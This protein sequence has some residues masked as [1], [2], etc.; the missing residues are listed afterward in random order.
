MKS[1]RH[2][3][4]LRR[5]G[6]ALHG[7]PKQPRLRPLAQ[8]VKLACLPTGIVLGLS[9]AGAVAGPQGGQIVG[10]QGAIVSPNGATTVINQASHNIAI[11]WDT[12]NV[13]VN[14]LVRFNQPGATSAA[15]NNIFDQSAS[16]IF[17]QIDANGRVFLM[18]PNGILFGPNA[19]IN[20]N[21]LVAAGARIDVDDFMA[22]NYT[23]QSLQDADGFVINRGVIEAATGGSVTLAGKTVR[24]EGLILA[25]AGRVNLVTGSRIALDFDG[26]GLMQFAVE[27]AVLDNA[28]SIDDGIS[29]T[30]DIIAD[31]GEVLITA[32]AAQGV[33]DNAINNE[34]LIK[35]GRI[36]NQG[37]TIRLVGMGPQS[38]IINTGVLTADASSGDGGS[39]EVVSSATTIIG[40][41]A[42]VSA[43]ADVGQG[44]S[45][46]IL[47]DRV[48]LTDAASIDVSGASGGEIL[49]GGDYQGNNPDV[50]NA[51][52]TYVGTDATLS[53]DAGTDG[54]GGRIIVWADGQTAF[55]GHLSAR[56]GSV[57][58]DGGF[59]EV[60]GKE[61]LQFAGT[62]DMQAPQGET[63][64]LLLD[65]ADIIIEGGVASAD[66][67]G[68]PGNAN[69]FGAGTVTISEAVIEGL[70]ADVSLL[71]EDTITVTGTF[72]QNTNGEGT[73]AILA[74]AS[75]K[76]LVM[77]TN[78]STATGGIDLTGT[79]VEIRTQGDGTITLTT[80]VAAAGKASP[81]TV[82]AITTGP[83]ASSGTDADSGSITLTAEGAITAGALTTGSATVTSAGGNDDATS[84]SITLTAGAGLITLNGALTTG[85]ASI[86]NGDSDA[87]SG[88]I[89]I[90][91]TNGGL[92]GTAN[93][94][95]TTGNATATEVGGNDNQIIISGSIVLNVDGAIVL[96]ANAAGMGDALRTG[97]PTHNS[98]ANNNDTVTVGSITIQQGGATSAPDSITDGSG[99]A[100]DVQIGTATTTQT[101]TPGFI[102]AKTDTGDIRL[103]SAEGLRVEALSTGG[104]AQNVSVTGT[105]AIVIIEDKTEALSGDNVTFD[106]TTGTLRVD[107][108]DFVIGTGTLSCGA[109]TLICW[110]LR[111]ASKG[112]AATS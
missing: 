55:F 42:V 58:G 87:I 105:G 99:G 74:L 34:G 78:N 73:G 49:F 31:G 48:G 108:T 63:G 22:G 107:D 59:A 67:G 57:S 97:N 82:G 93:G 30:G 110:V 51:S 100:V 19:R 88:G 106:A 112:A 61:N 65:P 95:I 32:S 35:A 80:G 96:P 16:Q 85:N 69:S 27:E 44:G 92:T 29:N 66:D 101:F 62:V 40:G 89:T 52:L 41:D 15:L 109:M 37:G 70:N 7:A 54:D 2:S 86:D 68:F 11:N 23:L 6:R 75:N 102:T 91:S 79:T 46:K 94:T 50:L 90:T 1:R 103:S 14:E 39:I 3:P 18:N 36:E 111:T 43:A 98:P 64:D 21:N 24:N 12:F 77:Q 13:G 84:G 26:D 53:A 45:V 56:G 20:I 76:D 83:D 4:R 9:A 5:G 17:G 47:G 38:S 71:A 28:A 104:G 72:D 81:I 8:H 60:S 25:N 33:F 10:G